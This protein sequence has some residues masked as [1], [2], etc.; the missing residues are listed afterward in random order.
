MAVDPMIARGV[1]PGEGVL[2]AVALAERIKGSRQENELSKL[3]LNLRQQEMQQGQQQAQA[4]QQQEAAKQ[5]MQ[6]LY[7]LVKQGNPEAVKLAVERASQ[8]HPQVGDLFKVDPAKTQAQLVAGMEQALGIK[9]EKPEAPAKPELRTVGDSLVQIDEQGARPIYTAPAKPEKA[10]APEKP[11]AAPSGYRFTGS[12]D[13]QAIPGGPADALS[14]QKLSPKDTNTA[15]VKIN[16]V[17][18]ARTQ[19]LRAKA[20]WNKIKGGMTAGPGQG[21]LPTAGG[22]AF[23]A[24]INAMRGSITSLT[25]VPGVGAMSDYETRLD[26]SKFP[27]RTSYESVTEE[28]M[29]GLED[30]LNNIESGYADLLDT[31][32][33]AAGGAA[34][35]VVNFEDL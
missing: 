33:K 5:E 24:A 17:K 13:L 15:R 29:Q 30:L 4:Q 25:R 6:W 2:A 8:S 19:L 34:P 28:Q 31:P 7:P 27:D 22:K 18:I 14:A 23:D 32:K 1:N 21:L 9:P 16:Q 11:P 3:A 35:G 26:Q 10:P 20:A 12:G